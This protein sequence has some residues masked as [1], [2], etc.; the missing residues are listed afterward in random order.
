MSKASES[1]M[2]A[3]KREIVQPRMFQVVNME[4]LVPQHHIL[5]KLN[6]AI[7]YDKIHDWVSGLYTESVGRPAVDPV[8]A[9]RLLLLCY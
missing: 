5:R 7:A 3:R 4:T 1:E 8:Q 6:R 2:R 9:V